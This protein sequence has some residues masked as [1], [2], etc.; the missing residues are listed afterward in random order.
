MIEESKYCS[1]EMK[2]CFNK[3]LVM[4]NEDNEDFQNSTR[5]GVSLKFGHCSVHSLLKI[6]RIITHEH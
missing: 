1:D 4:T 5:V 3:E 6:L 2:K